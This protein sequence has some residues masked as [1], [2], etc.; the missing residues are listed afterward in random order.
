MVHNHLNQI[1]YWQLQ[2]AKAKLSQL[3]KKAI[4]KGPQGIS[5][6]GIEEIIVLSKHDYDKLTQPKQSAW[7]FFRDS[8][9][10]GCELDLKR[11]PSL[12]RDADL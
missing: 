2:E 9:L 8:P 1:P 12:T 5:I 7:Q 4:D 6:R 3:I 10:V 11:D